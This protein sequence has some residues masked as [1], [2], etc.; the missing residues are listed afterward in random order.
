MANARTRFD[1][2]CEYLGR[3]HETATGTLFGKP[4]AMLR[5]RAFIAFHADG[6]GFK[7]HGR[8]RLQALAMADARFWDPMSAERPNPEWIWV[9]GQHFLR[10]DRLAV[11]SYRQQKEQGDSAVYRP[12]PTAPANGAPIAPPPRADIGSTPMPAATGQLT[13][14]PGLNWGDRI[15]Q[16]TGWMKWTTSRLDE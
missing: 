8:V 11:E 16:L 7:L 10:W 2:I 14:R 1:T 15:K 4:C 9:P 5:G 6:M 13:T 12:K 3:A